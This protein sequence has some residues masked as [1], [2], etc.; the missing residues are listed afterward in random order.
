MKQLAIR[1]DGA[2]GKVRPTQNADVAV[3]FV[4]IENMQAQAARE[5]LDDITCRDNGAML[6][7]TAHTERGQRWL[8][9]SIGMHYGAGFVFERD[10]EIDL[11]RAMA[12]EGLMIRRN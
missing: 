4:R 11:A 5:A 1:R 6:F 3:P 8:D 10:Q 12:D 9:R 7:V 2:V